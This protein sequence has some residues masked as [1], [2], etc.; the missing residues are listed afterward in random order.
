VLWG[1]YAN[2]QRLGLCFAAIKALT[3]L[4]VEFESMNENPKKTM[5]WSQCPRHKRDHGQ[6]HG[7]ERGRFVVDA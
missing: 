6:Y 5:L 2:R 7:R 1:C 3:R 4:G